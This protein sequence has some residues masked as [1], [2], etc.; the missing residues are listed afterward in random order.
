MVSK[1]MFKSEKDTWQTPEKICASIENLYPDGYLDPAI[2]LEINPNMPGAYY[3]SSLDYLV[4]DWRAKNV[5]VNP[6][7]GR[8]VGK[9]TDK[10]QYEFAMGHFEN[11]IMLLPGRLGAKWFQRITKN[12]SCWCALDGR[13]TFVGATNSAPFP[14]ALVLFTSNADF[15]SAFINEYCEMGLL[16]RLV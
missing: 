2:P 12:S 8:V 11:G 5:Y 10:F 7:Y 15:L 1:V 13:L 14:S 4:E 6:P 16:W 3:D 9:W